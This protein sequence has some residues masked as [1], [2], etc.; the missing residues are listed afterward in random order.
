MSA[1]HQY[2]DPAH[3]IREVRELLHAHGLDPQMA[4]GNSALATTGASK[5]LRAFGITPAM[6]AVDALARSMDKPWVDSDDQ[7][8]EHRAASG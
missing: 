7:A 3:L 6:D 5:L 1:N 8:A 2:Y 4:P